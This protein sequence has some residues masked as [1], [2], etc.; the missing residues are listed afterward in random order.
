MNIISRFF[1]IDQEQSLKGTAVLKEDNSKRGF[2]IDFSVRGADDP[3]KGLEIAGTVN[4]DGIAQ[5]RP[6][7]GTLESVDAGPT[8]TFAF[9]D[10]DLVEHRF[11]GAVQGALMFG[12]A[13][14]DEG[15][16][17]RTGEDGPWAKVSSASNVSVLSALSSLRI[18]RRPKRPVYRDRIKSFLDSKPLPL[19]MKKTAV[20]LA[21]AMFPR[22]EVIEGGGEHTIERLEKSPLVKSNTA[23]RVLGAGLFGVEWLSWLSIG[24][25]FSRSSPEERARFMENPTAAGSAPKR[26]LLRLA[27][28]PIRIPLLLLVSALKY[29]NIASEETHEKLGTTRNYGV[30]PELDADLKQ[31]RPAPDPPEPWEAQIVPSEKFDSDEVIEADAVV[32]GTGAGGGPVAKELAERGF[33]VAVIESGK[34]LRREDPTLGIQDT[35]AAVGNALILLPI[36]R[37]VGGTTFINAGTC[38]RTPDEILMKWVDMGMPEFHPD[39][40]ASYFDSVEEII[41]VEEADPKWVGPVGEVIKKGCDVLGYHS[42][43][44]RRNCPNCEGK[45]L[46]SVGCPHGA[47][48]STNR[49]YIPHALKSKA[50]LFPGFKVKEILTNGERAIGVHAYGRGRDGKTV[51]LT[52]FARAVVLAAGAYLSPAL[53]QRNGLVRGNKWVG[54]NLTFHPA[55]GC[56]AVVPGVTMRTHE[57][58][59][60]GYCVDEF[61]KEG[62]MFEGANVPLMA[63]AL[64]QRGAGKKYVDMVEKFPNMANFGYMVEDTSTGRIRPGI[65]ERPLVTYWMNRTDFNKLVRGMATLA[66]IFLAAGAEQTFAMT[67]NSYRMAS[68]E[69]VKKF[70][71]RKW[72]PRDFI[73]SAYHGLGSARV[74]PSPEVSALNV[75]HQMHEVPGLFVVDGSA[76]PTS[77]GVNPQETIMAVATRAGERIAEILED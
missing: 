25:R 50:S 13:R 16:L 2:K 27:S 68:E 46:C 31:E 24:K 53:I 76:V 5:D 64:M 73:L 59:P 65:G 9:T 4:I 54:A 74:G 39:K 22:G 56:A 72:R 66:R 20:Q 23:L 34:Y 14:V 12:R 63:W 60:Q 30:A 57:C 71:S 17:T 44:L 52:V 38:F 45:A 21:E 41:H 11:E 43:N 6:F 35:T 36:G 48:Q 19:P 29:F 69:D 61:R 3:E 1:T 75:D 70:E 55:T 77:V 49:S 7:I 33:A 62:L 40:M 58:I 47:K 37:V 51:R 28:A 15:R 42:H 32:V 10:D 18:G 8:M 26:V 67:W